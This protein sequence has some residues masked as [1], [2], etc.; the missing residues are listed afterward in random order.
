MQRRCTASKCLSSSCLYC[1]MSFSFDNCL[2]CS[3]DDRAVFLY[4][5]SLLQIGIGGACSLFFLMATKEPTSEELK[6]RS[7]FA[8][9]L[10]KIQDVKKSKDLEPVEDFKAYERDDSGIKGA[11]KPVHGGHQF[12]DAV[13][14]FGRATSDCRSGS[15]DVYD[16]QYPKVNSIDEFDELTNHA[17]SGSSEDNEKHELLATLP[18][19]SDSPVQN[20]RESNASEVS[21]HV[22]KKWSDWFKVPEFYTVRLKLSSC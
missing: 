20:N 13:K 16:A 21:H 2:A 19:E 11:R 3:S 9:K 17:Y 15:I 1:G 7:K 4:I 5:I 22:P 14:E 8:R 18:E 12:T 10:M 6:E